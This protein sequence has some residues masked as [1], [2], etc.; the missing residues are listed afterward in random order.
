MGGEY[1]RIYTWAG[2][3]LQVVKELRRLPGQPCAL[4]E[5]LAIPS[6][7]TAS[8]PAFYGISREIHKDFLL[9]PVVMGP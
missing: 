7:H 6:D 2:T 9:F 4:V 8:L 1:H 3:K 5:A